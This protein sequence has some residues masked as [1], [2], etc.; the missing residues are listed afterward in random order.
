MKRSVVVLLV[1]LGIV[2]VLAVSLGFYWPFSGNHRVLTLPGTVEVHELRLG[3]KVGGRVAEVNIREGDVVDASKKL[4]RFDAPELQAQRD[5][6][7]AKVMSAQA[8]Y[9]KAENGPRAQ[10]RAEAKKAMDAAEARKNRMEKGWREEEK[11]QAEKDWEAAKADLDYAKENWER[12]KSTK[13][14]SSLELESAHSRYKVALG[15][16]GS[17]KAKWDMIRSGNRTEDIADARAQFE[18]AKARYEL[19]EAGTREEDKRIARAQL[20][21]VTARLKELD[22]NLAETIVTAPSKIFVEVLSVR[23]GDLVPANQ[24]VIRALLADERWVKVFAPQNELGKMHVGDAVEVTCD[25][26]PGKTFHGTIIQIAT[27]SE[28]TPRNVQSADERR[29]QVFAVKVRVEDDEGRVF[30]SGMAAEV[31]VPL[32][33]K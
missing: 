11:E 17:A 21:E 7:A 12:T 6:F 29:H 32:G 1:G 28:F 15:R 2:A 33:G 4:L 26:F 31:R 23:K 13:E 20:A 9:E 18:Q 19:L 30:K 27:A 10:E 8:D 3:S 16:Y 22:A 5:Q 14:V 24:P 25:T